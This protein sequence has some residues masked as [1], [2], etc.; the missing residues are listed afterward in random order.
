MRV[1]NYGAGRANIAAGRAIY[2]PIEPGQQTPTARQHGHNTAN[3]RR[4]VTSNN[5]QQ[6]NLTQQKRS[7]DFSMASDVRYI[8][9]F[10]NYPG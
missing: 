9:S 3:M 10:F 2:H 5:A 6:R 7:C 4:K 8:V 1:V